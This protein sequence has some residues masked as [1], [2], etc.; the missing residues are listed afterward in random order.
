MALTH[1]SPAGRD[2]AGLEYDLCVGPRSRRSRVSHTHTCHVR[3]PR[4]R[5]PLT[6]FT[7]DSVTS[8]LQNSC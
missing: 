6:H 8:Q 2:G 4:P 3:V 5:S 1:A 7:L